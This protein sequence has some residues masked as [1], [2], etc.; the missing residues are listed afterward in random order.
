MSI[1]VSRILVILLTLYA[2]SLW[3]KPHFVGA[4]ECAECHES[5]HDVW[6]DTKH[7]SSFKKAHRAREARKIAKA[8]GGRNMKKTELCATC[9]YT[10]VS[11]KLDSGPSCESCHGPASEWID[12]HNDYGG[13]GVKKE[14]ETAAHKE[15]RIAKSISAGMIQPS[16]LFGVAMNCNSCHGF[17]TDELSADSITKM[18]DAGHPLTSEFEL[19]SYAN[20]SVRHRFYPPDV[21]LNKEMSLSEQ[22]EMYVVGQ[23][24]ALITAK[25]SVD[26]S[27]HPK[28]KSFQKA[29]IDAAKSVLSTIPEAKTFI[30]NPT[31]V[32]GRKLVKALPNI[33]KV[34]SIKKF[35][36]KKF[37]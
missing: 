13:E 35:L 28:F 20:G 8:V 9:H 6:K 18:V 37:K 23:V 24:V 33:L 16:N 10:V 26:K 11:A 17:G 31:E 3:A 32:E 27:D 29:R 1:N 30:E 15:D 2:S 36:P 19:V 7:F 34:D 5:S 22:A 21:T 4:E 25:S 12:I 14:Q